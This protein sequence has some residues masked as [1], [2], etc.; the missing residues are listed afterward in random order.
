MLNWTSGDIAR[1]GGFRFELRYGT[2]LDG[3]KME[4][5]WYLLCERP[6]TK[7]APW[8]G[9]YTERSLRFATADDA[10]AFCEKI[11]AGEVIL[12]QLKEAE[13]KAYEAYQAKVLEKA[14]AQVDSFMNQLKQWGVSPVH[15]GKVVSAYLKLGDKAKDIFSQRAEQMKDEVVHLDLKKLTLREYLEIYRNDIDVCLV[16]KDTGEH[17]LPAICYLTKEEIASGDYDRDPWEEW[18]LDL[19]V[20]SVNDRNGCV[21]AVV[22]TDFSLDETNFLL[23]T[24]EFETYQWSYLY[25]RAV[26]AGAEFADRLA[27]LKEGKPFEKPFDGTCMDVLNAHES[28]DLYAML[29]ESTNVF[30]ASYPYHEDKF[31]AYSYHFDS[32]GR[33]V[34]ER[35]LDIKFTEPGK[36]MVNSL[37]GKMYWA[38]HLAAKEREENLMNHA[39]AK[40]TGKER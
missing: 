12:A 16:D 13:T 5:P 31:Y 14:H 9:T 19:P 7:N 26:W 11:V 27:Y 6:A 35:E 28:S 40:E 29:V 4:K 33:A 32:K 3:E 25:E 10:K 39:P 15:V 23:D 24:G 21:E 34:S 18:V 36:G 8:E 2:W 30:V 22:K 1:K 37:N 17:S 20:E 38:Q